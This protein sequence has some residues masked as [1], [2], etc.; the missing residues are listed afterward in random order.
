MKL[1]QKQIWTINIASTVM[2]FAIM[3]VLN[4]HIERKT[5]NSIFATQTSLSTALN[6]KAINPLVAKIP[7]NTEAS[8]PIKMISVPKW[9]IVDA[10]L[11]L[12]NITYT[13]AIKQIT[14]SFYEYSFCNKFLLLDKII[15]SIKNKDVW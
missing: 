8:L 4:N 6:K 1:T 2:L 13:C 11:R 5:P 3:L 12:S 15:E 14:Y 7:Q 9:S 10:Q